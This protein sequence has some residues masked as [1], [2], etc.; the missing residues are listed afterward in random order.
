MRNSLAIL[1]GIAAFA[2]PALALAAP[3]VPEQFYG[4]VSYDS[5]ATPSGLVVVAYAGGAAVASSITDSSGEYGVSPN[6]LMVPDTNG[7]LAGT[8]VTFTVN[9]SA[10]SQTATFANAALTKL[11][12]SVSGAA[13]GTQTSTNSSVGSSGGGGGGG[14]VAA[15]T[16]T[17]NTTT[18]TVA[19]TDVN[20]DGR[21]DFLDFNALMVHWG[22]AGTNIIGDMNGDGVVDFLD[23]NMLM[24][25]WTTS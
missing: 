10:V 16:G 6:L 4:S 13:P 8:I 23:F 14:S 3:G 5:G 19:S 15:V 25:N 1:A 18:T 20:G 7:A 11:D 17:S 22:D 21:T 12:L 9:G 2:L 24:V